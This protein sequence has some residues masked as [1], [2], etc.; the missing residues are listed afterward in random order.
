MQLPNYLIDYIILHELA[1]TREH[2]HGEGF[3]KLLN[4][5]TESKARQLDKEIRKNHKII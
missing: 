3:W 2:N 1:H 4:I 5:L